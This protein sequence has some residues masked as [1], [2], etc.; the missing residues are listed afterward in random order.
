MTDKVKE[1]NSELSGTRIKLQVLEV[2]YAKCAQ[3]LEEWQLRTNKAE[4]LLK[5]IEKL[6][7]INYGSTIYPEELN[8]QHHNMIRTPE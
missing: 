8:N 3:K 7:V 1:L 2:E 4:E 6:V 5:M